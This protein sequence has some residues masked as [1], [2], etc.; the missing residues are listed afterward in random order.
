MASRWPLQPAAQLYVDLLP[1]GPSD[2]WMRA[3]QAGLSSSWSPA[4]LAA[5][6]GAC[7]FHPSRVPE[8]LLAFL[9][10]PVPRHHLGNARYCQ[11]LSGQ[12]GRV[13]SHGVQQCMYFSQ[14]GLM[15][16][17]LGCLLLSHLCTL[18]GGHRL[19]ATETQGPWSP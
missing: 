7:I 6:T 17:K 13:C 19:S 18:F 1:T 4:E 14:T 12:Q 2:R 16:A 9:V 3:A 8:A 15:L 11:A 5:A 10:R